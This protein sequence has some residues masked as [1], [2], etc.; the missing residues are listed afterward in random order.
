MDILF[1]FTLAIHENG[2]DT[3]EFFCVVI[4]SRNDALASPE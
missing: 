3:C 2:P 1:V 4:F